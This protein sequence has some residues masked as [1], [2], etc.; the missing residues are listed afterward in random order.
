MLTV[1]EQITLQSV[2]LDASLDEVQK[3]LKYYRK[4]LERNRERNLKKY[5]EN[6]EE[7]NAKRRGAN[8]KKVKEVEEVEAKEV[9]EAKEFATEQDELKHHKEVRET[10]FEKYKTFIHEQEASE[11]KGK[12]FRRAFISLLRVGATTVFPTKEAEI[13]FARKME[14]DYPAEK[15]SKMFTK[16]AMDTVIQFATEYAKY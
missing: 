2:E 10:A 6:K 5:H 16:T 3:A 11:A 7:I 13:K 4:E 9:E 8:K 12:T 1:T 15:I 14:E